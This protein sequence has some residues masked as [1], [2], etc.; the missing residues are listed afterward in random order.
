MTV[1]HVYTK[2]VLTTEILSCWFIFEGISSKNGSDVKHIDVLGVDMEKL[3]G[4]VRFK[5]KTSHCWH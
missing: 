2:S 5:T 1:M 3:N 4:H